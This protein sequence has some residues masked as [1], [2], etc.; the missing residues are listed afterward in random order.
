MAFGYSEMCVR[1]VDM[2]QFKK[3]MDDEFGE[4]IECGEIDSDT[5][6]V[7]WECGGLQYGEDLAKKMVKSWDSIL[8]EGRSSVEY[9]DH[10]VS[11]NFKFDGKKLF[12]SHDLSLRL[13]Y[14]Y[15]EDERDEEIQEEIDG[16]RMELECDYNGLPSRE[17]TKEELMK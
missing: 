5:F 7:N 17:F 13:E 4:W 11:I 8:F 3:W 12:I 9:D 10:I 2:E 15:D 1:K 6:E 14:D 16:L